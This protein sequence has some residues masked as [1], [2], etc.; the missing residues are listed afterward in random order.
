MNIEILDEAES[1]LS[2]AIEHYDDIEPGLG[3]RLKNEVRFFIGEI[4]RDPDRPRVR[5]AG[6]RRVNLSVFPF[7]IAYY[8][9][10][11][12]IWIVAIAHAHRR[13]EYWLT[14]N[15]RMRP[16]GSEGNI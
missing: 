11:E 10:R 16:S 4:E 1:E 13:P 3:V 14:R 5:N 9:I 2:E 7:F 8:L 12:T 6:Y 15:K